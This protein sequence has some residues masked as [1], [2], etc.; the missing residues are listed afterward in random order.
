MYYLRQIEQDIQAN[1]A[2]FDKLEDIYRDAIHMKLNTG[3]YLMHNT[4]RKAIGQP[5]RTTGFP[6]ADPAIIEYL[7]ELLKKDFSQ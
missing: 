4:V 1:Q 2:P 5:M 3:R 7:N 6:E